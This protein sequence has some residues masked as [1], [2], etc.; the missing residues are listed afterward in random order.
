M[1]DDLPGARTYMHAVRSLLDLVA[2]TQETALDRAATAIVNAIEADGILY[3][4]GT[5]HSHMLAE[6]GHTRAG[7]LAAVC[8][9]LASSLMI[10][11]SSHAGSLLER[12]AGIGPAILSRYQPTA[13]DVIVVF[14][15]SGVNAVPVETALAAK[16]IGMTV[17][18]MVA[19]EYAAVAPLS[20]LGKRLADV[21]DIVIDNGG[22]P[23]DALVE[24]GNTGLRT[25]A[26]STV[27]GAFLLNALLSEVACRLAKK[28]GTP[29]V[30]VS[31]NLP[32]AA[33][34]NTALHDRYRAR[35]PHL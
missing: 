3:L 24:I 23:G 6:E 29:P 28:G 19:L 27:T 18:A 17:I 11:E 15:N 30:Y 14:S 8:P 35:N 12:T 34:H 2:R 25:G 22:P 31:S 26:A 33:G 10:H 4:F 9:I 5:G 16:K 20:A 32:G 13:K 21:A 7:G 1:P